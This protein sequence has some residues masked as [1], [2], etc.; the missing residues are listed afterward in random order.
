MQVI[1]IE[2]KYGQYT[3]HVSEQSASITRP[4][5]L[6]GDD[7][8]VSAALDVFEST[9]VAFAAAGF[10]M[11]SDKAAAALDAALDAILNHIE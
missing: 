7:A 5:G 4:K 2:T 9:V 3:L 8:E 6:D 1:V 11:D 10:E